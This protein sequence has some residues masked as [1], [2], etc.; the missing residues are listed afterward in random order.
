MY[1]HFVPRDYYELNTVDDPDLLRVFEHLQPGVRS[2]TDDFATDD[3]A[4]DAE[5]EGQEQVSG[6]GSLKESRRHIPTR[7]ELNNHIRFIYNYEPQ[8]LFLGGEED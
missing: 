1:L 4:P 8:P 5:E 3:M 7:R 2:N 6:Q